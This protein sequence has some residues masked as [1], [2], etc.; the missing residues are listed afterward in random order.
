MALW[1]R[2]ARALR[3]ALCRAVPLGA[4]EM[5]LPARIVPT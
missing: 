2:T 3:A 1:K 4:N 5:Q